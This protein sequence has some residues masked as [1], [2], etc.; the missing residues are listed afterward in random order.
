MTTEME[1]SIKQYLKDN[2]SIRVDV[3]YDRGW[4]CNRVEV[5][6]LMDNEVID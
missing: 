4:G 2:M 5:T 3:G 1:Q 6:L